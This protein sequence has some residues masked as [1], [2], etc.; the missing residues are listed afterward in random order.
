M[1]YLVFLF[2]LYIFTVVALGG[3]FILNTA[4]FMFHLVP[5]PYVKGFV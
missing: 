1:G 5:H 3:L 2:P 4:H